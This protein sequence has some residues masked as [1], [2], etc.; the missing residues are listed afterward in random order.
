[1][2]YYPKALT[3]DDVLPLL[4]IL[5]KFQPLIED[6]SQVYALARCSE[7]LLQN[8]ENPLDPQNGLLR[9]QYDDLWNIIAEGAF[10]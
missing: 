8:E 6:P 1:M 9:K 5:S 2:S 4:T 3:T 10:R 7:V